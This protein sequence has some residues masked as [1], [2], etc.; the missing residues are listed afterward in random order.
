MLRPLAAVVLLGGSTLLTTPAAPAAAAHRIDPVVLEASA[1]S[2][3]YARQLVLTAT[4]AAPQPDAKV[5]I[6]AKAVGGAAKLVGSGS[7]GDAR[8][9]V[10]LPVTSTATYYAVLV[11][12]GAPTA[13]SLSVDVV[14]APSLV[15]KA[16]QMVG[17]VYHFIATAKPAVDGTP[18]VLQRLVGKKWK[19]I[20]K[21]VTA[22]GQVV[23]TEGI[24]GD[25]TSKW[26]LFVRGSRKYGEST[27]RTVRVVDPG[28]VR[29]A[30]L[31][32]R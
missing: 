30:R 18:I 5:D 21:D 12:A 2:V 4:V 26:R 9:K 8:A 17:P 23:F 31:T 11:V 15:L 7:S 24:P 14:V 32:A 19:K 29:S 1:A 27:S 13:Q 6:Y 22:D 28:D 25:V 16:E 10:T 20:E 3:P